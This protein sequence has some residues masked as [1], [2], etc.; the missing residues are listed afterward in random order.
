MAGFVVVG[1]SLSVVLLAV[2]LIGPIV[3]PSV[4]PILGIT[5]DTT[6]LTLFFFMFATIYN[7]ILL[8]TITL[9]DRKHS[10]EGEAQ[11]HVF[12]LMIPCRNEGGC[13]ERT[14]RALMNIDYSIHKFE[15]LV[16]NDG[17]TDD[18]EEV[19]CRLTRELPNLRLLNVPVEDSGRG[20]SEA[21]NK[22]FNYL[23][24]VSPFKNNLNWIIGVFD[25][26]GIAERTILKKVSYPFKNAK[27]GAV[28]TLVRIINS[29]QSILTMLQDIE[30]VTF[31]KV[32]QFA[33]NIFKGAVALGGNGQFTRA[34]ALRSIELS[35]GKYWRDDALTEDL[36]LGTRI[37]LNGWENSF[38]STTAVHQFGVTTLSDLYKQRTRWSWGAI[39]CFINYA[40]K[41]Q[42]LKSKMGL[43]R[44][45]DLVY[46]LSA[47]I[48]PPI[49]LVVWALSI[50]SLLGLFLINNPFPAYFMIINSISFFPLIGY[51]LWSVRQEYKAKLI[52]PL[53]IL[54]SAY[55]YHWVICTLRAMIHVIKKEKPRWI[56]TKKT[57]GKLAIES[58]VKHLETSMAC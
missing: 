16:I 2:C 7:A 47:A 58:N 38:L 4:N 23:L 18:T 27:I 57:S 3:A 50:L 41:L 11:E 36:D 6:L 5:V 42:V 33:R 8:T 54:T 26:D 39:Q 29:K 45:F 46:Y 1:L 25:S 43:V 12:S 35:P 30:F 44:K 40:A 10:F 49:I 24:T 51:G 22:G 53:L 48:M 17:S 32:T 15:V 34:S 20:K 9:H 21:L 13:I 31:A 52:I 55:T 37:L 14:I 19:V 28:Q 56:V